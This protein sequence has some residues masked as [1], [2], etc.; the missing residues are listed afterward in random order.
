[1]NKLTVVLSVFI[2]LLISV[3]TA[4]AFE[5]TFQNH[6]GDTLTGGDMWTSETYYAGSA[7]IVNTPYSDT[8][9]AQVSASY[10]APGY[11]WAWAKTNIC[12]CSNYW[13]FSVVGF[14]GDTG[15]TCVTFRFFD[16]DNVFLGSSSDMDV[17]LASY[18]SSDHWEMLRSGDTFGLYINGVY[19]GNLGGTYS[20]MPCYMRIRYS[21]G[22]SAGSITFD[23]F[24]NYGSIVGTWEHDTEIIRNWDNPESSAPTE[25][26]AS[27]AWADTIGY[28]EHN[29]PADS[30][31]TKHFRTGEVINVTNLSSSEPSEIIEYNVS[32]LLYHE[33]HDDDKYGLYLQELRQ[34]GLTL[35]YDHFF[36][37]FDHYQQESGSVDFDKEVYVAGEIAKL[38][39]HLSSPSF[40]DYSYYCYV[41]DSESQIKEQWTLVA[42]DETHNS[43]TIGYDSG[44]YYVILTAKDK[45]TSF[46]YDLDWDVMNINEEI[47]VRGVTYNTETESVLGSVPVKLK[48]GLQYYN[49]TSNSSTGEYNVTP[50][51][52]DITTEVNASKTN[53]VHSNFTFVPLV[54]GVYE[55]DLFLLPDESHITHSGTSI[56]GLVREI[57]F[58][59]EVS[60]ATVH[61][62]NDTWS[63]FTTTNSMGYYKFDNLV[64]DSG[65]NLNATAAG[66]TSSENE[67]V[68][69]GAV[70][71]YTYHYITLPRLFDLT[72]KARHVSTHDLI[73]EFTAGFNDGEITTKTTNGTVRFD[74]P[75]GIWKVE[76]YADNFYGSYN[77]VYIANTASTT[78]YLTPMEEEGGMG[79][80]YAP[81]HLVEFRVVDI[82][83]VPLRDINVNATGFETTLV[84]LTWLQK[85]F[86]YSSEIEVYNTTMEGTTDYSGAISF[87]MVETIKY[88][89]TFINASQNISAYREIYPK[90][91]RYIVTIGEVPTQKIAYWITSEQNNTA[92]T[93]NITLHYSDYNTPVKTNWVNFSVYYLENNSLVFSHNFTTINE[94][95]EN[96]S[97]NLN[98]SYSYKVKCVADHDDFGEFKWYITVIFVVPEKSKLPVVQ[99]MKDSLEDWQLQTFSIFVIILFAL[100]FGGGSQG[101]AG[102]VVSFTAI[103]FHLFGM[104]PLV[105]TVAGAV[106]YPLLAVMA[107]VNLLGERREE[108]A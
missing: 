41:Q 74:V 24:S 82:W 2:V 51:S 73:S 93:G 100:I 9:A 12:S 31:I 61:I 101:V 96:T 44:V 48:Q 29:P 23:D 14:S 87:M 105:P 47:L 20:S 91:D 45:S 84:N 32:T 70:N 68:T 80:Y 38:T 19:K 95:N 30:L 90:D 1:M 16:S 52:K 46:Q 89:M 66:H 26:H 107:I 78:L 60:S 13:S 28:E 85:L 72:V 83:G 99:T 106:V 63:D 4:S 57:P 10:S 59:Q 94:T 97:I 104:M 7:T 64:N 35:A 98:A 54:N 34:G 22:A 5:D 33:D 71:S 86:G 88:K 39:T 76:A 49:D 37:N 27:Y 103:G 43:D 53:Y 8:K 65:Y 79:T 15:Y 77:Y 69:T 67:E 81:P 18:H 40:A 42:I 92:N 102:M 58:N 108:P 55:I 36:Y 56:G 6:P 21:S 25:F 3:S 62:W 75:Y 50:L 17:Y 11:G